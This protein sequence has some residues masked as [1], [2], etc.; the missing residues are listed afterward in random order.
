MNYIPFHCNTD[1]IHPQLPWQLQGNSGNQF[2]WV[3]PK[4]KP[5]FQDLEDVIRSY[6]IYF[7]STELSPSGALFSSKTVT[8]CVSGN[9]EVA[10]SVVHLH[11]F[12]QG[13]NVNYF[14]S[15]GWSSCCNLKIT[16]FY[17]NFHDC[18]E[19]R[20]FLGRYSVHIESPPLI[21]V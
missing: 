14:R 13:V 9:K 19:T 12:I 8:S 16:F 17:S 6:C 20:L 10:E 2:I 7:P 15:R 4:S 5:Y 21:K 18:C 3:Y 11:V 1:H